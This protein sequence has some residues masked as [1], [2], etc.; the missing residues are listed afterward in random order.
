MCGMKD[1]LN[2]LNPIA[3]RWLKC[4]YYSTA[5]LGLGF[6]RKDGFCILFCL[7]STKS[8]VLSYNCVSV[9]LEVIL[10]CPKMYSVVCF[11]QL[12]RVVLLHSHSDAYSVLHTVLQTFFGWLQAVWLR[13]KLDAWVTC[14]SAS[15][16]SGVMCEE[17]NCVPSCN[18]MCE[19]LLHPEPNSSL[20][21]MFSLEC[22]PLC[23]LHQMPKMSSTSVACQL[24]L[25]QHKIFY[26]YSHLKECTY[27][28]TFCLSHVCRV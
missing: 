1:L 18:E 20:P 8:L 12:P 10:F 5:E 21:G 24:V 19:L 25:L 3:G 23:T 2:G 9:Q 27:L 17:G 6:W 28:C 4:W 13:S 22:S 14:V 11:A 26:S 15:R 7:W 16:A